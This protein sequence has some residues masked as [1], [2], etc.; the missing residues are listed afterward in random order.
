MVLCYV[1]RL[2]SGMFSGTVSHPQKGA[3]RLLKTSVKERD[4]SFHSPPQPLCQSSAHNRCSSW[5]RRQVGGSGS[6]PGGAQ[7]VASERSQENEVLF[8]QGVMMFTPP[9]P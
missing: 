2:V 5:V 6:A 1:R 7:G 8:P 3:V 4:L 9:S